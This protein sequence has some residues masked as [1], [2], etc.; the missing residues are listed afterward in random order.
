MTQPKEYIKT[1]RRDNSVIVEV[2]EIESSSSASRSLS[3]GH[4]KRKIGFDSDESGSIN[5][6]IS[7]ATSKRSAKNQENDG[8]PVCDFSDNKAMQKLLRETKGFPVERHNSQSIKFEGQPKLNLKQQQ[9]EKKKPH[10][11]DSTKLTN[12]MTDPK[13][14][15]DQEWRLRDSTPFQ[16][17]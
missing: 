4:A 13:L 7:I 17:D 1:T 6:T 10:K 15:E 12:K 8:T 3:E 9:S 14:H 16:L 2:Q 11:I 5:V